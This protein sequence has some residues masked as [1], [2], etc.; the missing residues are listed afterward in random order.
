MGAFNMHCSHH[1]PLSSIV[2]QI[3]MPKNNEPKK[4]KT[5]KPKK[6]KEEKEE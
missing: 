4:E 5:G 1:I 3:G 2:A 6:V